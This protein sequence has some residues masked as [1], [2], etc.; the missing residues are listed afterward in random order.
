VR[1]PADEQRLQEENAEAAR[2]AV[3]V[4]TCCATPCCGP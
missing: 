2:R 4:P 1:A 3:R